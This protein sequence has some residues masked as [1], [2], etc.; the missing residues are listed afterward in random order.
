MEADDKVKDGG[1]YNDLRYNS[2]HK[3][4]DFSEIESNRMIKSERKFPFSE[5]K[6]LWE[7]VEES[8]Q[9]RITTLAQVD[10]EDTLKMEPKLSDF[11]K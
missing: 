10:E 5:S 6:I 2:G 3:G 9:T 4:E 7:F 11:I 1:C 8:V